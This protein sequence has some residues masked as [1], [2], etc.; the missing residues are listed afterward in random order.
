M[1]RRRRFGLSVNGRHLTNRE[2]F[3]Q[4]SLEFGALEI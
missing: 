3:P 1:S 2:I 4:T